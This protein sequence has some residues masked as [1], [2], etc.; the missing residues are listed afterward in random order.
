MALFFFG[1]L[2]THIPLIKALLP[3]PSRGLV[4]NVT[5]LDIYA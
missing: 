1:Q 5:Q 2:V 4:S 3:R